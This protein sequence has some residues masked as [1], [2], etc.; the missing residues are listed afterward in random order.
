MFGTILLILQIIGAIPDVIEFARKLWEIIKKIRDKKVRLAKKKELRRIV[1]KRRHLKTVS[2]DEQ[3][4]LM[5]E[6]E[7]LKNEVEAIIYKEVNH[8]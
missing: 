8:D 6:L 4:V 1:F 7:N 3:Q 5:N 2:S